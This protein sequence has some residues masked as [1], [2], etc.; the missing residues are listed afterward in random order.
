MPVWWIFF[1]SEITCQQ[2][3]GLDPP[4]SSPVITKETI[5]QVLY[6]SKPDSG[7]KQKKSS[8]LRTEGW[9]FFVVNSLLGE[10]SWRI[11]PVV[12]WLVTPIYKPSRPFGRGTTR[13]LGDLLTMVSWTARDPQKIGRGEIANEISV[14]WKTHPIRTYCWWNFAGWILDS[15]P[16]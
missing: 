13:S 11:T 9:R 7:G 10:A 3:L 4:W 8:R 5:H 6:T 12:K 14:K 2:I 16:Q 1:Q 15:R